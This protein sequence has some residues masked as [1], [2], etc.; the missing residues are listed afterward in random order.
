MGA[1]KHI[2]AEKRKEETETAYLEGAELYFQCKNDAY[3]EKSFK[4]GGCIP[5]YSE[6]Q[7]GFRY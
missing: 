2:S 3:A 4:R 7:Y 5:V 1:R 6:I